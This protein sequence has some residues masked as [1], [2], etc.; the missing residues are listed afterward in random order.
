MPAARPRDRDAWMRAAVVVA[1]VLPLGGCYKPNIT[2]NGFQ[3]APTGKQCPDGYKCGTDNRC[4]IKP[5]TTPPRDS[6]TETVMMTDA[7][8]DS[9]CGAVTPVCQTGPATGDLC[10]PACQK[11]CPCG[12]CNVVNGKPA[13]VPAGTIKL[14]DVCT[15]G[16]DDNCGPG[17]ICLIESC[18]NG[19]ARCYR[20]CSANDQCDGTAC[21]IVIDDDKGAPTPYTTCDVPPRVCDPVV[22]TGCPDPALN[23]YLTSANQTL[24][25]CPTGPAMEG[26]NNAPCMIYSD[27]ASGFICISGVNGQTT[28]HC[29]FVCDVAKPSCP[30]AGGDGGQMRCVPA[31]TGAKYGYC[32]L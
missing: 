1:V 21:T 24:C 8:G 6:A 13:C 20:H 30:S 3:C 12:R 15:P 19:L 16:A 25:D 14:G 5:V 7:G 4:S 29:H 26:M 23:C 32:A 27:C 17:L 10:S 22:G 31:G 11:G 2:D 9:M 28:P 18:G